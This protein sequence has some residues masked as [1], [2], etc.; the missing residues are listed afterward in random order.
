[1]KQDRPDDKTPAEPILGMAATGV[2][3]FALSAAAWHQLS[4]ASWG[5]IG[6]VACLVLGALGAAVS[7][8]RS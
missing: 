8:N 4:P 6:W 1:M 3:T 5:T 2:L 7:K